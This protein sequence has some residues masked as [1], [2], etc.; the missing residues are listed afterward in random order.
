MFFMNKKNSVELCLVLLICGIIIGLKNNVIAAE[1]LST[2][3]DNR[4]CVAMDI[5]NY[6][7]YVTKVD[8]GSVYKLNKFGVIE[9]NYKYYVK[10]VYRFVVPNDGHISVTINCIDS[11]DGKNNS[12]WLWKE[13][14]F[15]DDTAEY[16]D[17]EDLRC[18]DMKLKDYNIEGGT[19]GWYTLKAGTYYIGGNIDG[20]TTNSTIVIN[21]QA[22]GAY[23]G[24]S[25]CHDTFDRA[26]NLKSGVVYQGDNYNDGFGSN[27]YSVDDDSICNKDDIY[28]FTMSSPGKVTIDLKS[29]SGKHYYDIYSESAD[30]NVTK[31]YD[32]SSTHTNLRLPQGNYYIVYRPDFEY[33]IC[34]TTV[35]ES[36]SQYEQEFNNAS[37]F[38]NEI[39][40]NQSYLGNINYGDDKD[41]YK[42]TINNK[43]NVVVSL[44]IP[45]Q[46]SN[47]A[48]VKLYDHTLKKELVSA[49]T[50]RNPVLYLK[51]QILEAGTYYVCVSG[52]NDFESDYTLT[53]NQADNCELNKTKLNLK[54]GKTGK[55]SLKGAKGNVA[56]TS[57]NKKVATV[58][59]SGKVKVTGVGNA[60]I[61][62][63]YGGR[64][65]TCKVKGTCN[66]VKGF[67]GDYSAYCKITKIKENKLYVTIS[68]SGETYK[69]QFKMNSS[70]TKA[71]VTFKC[72]HKKQHKITISYLKKKDTLSGSEKTKCK[73]KLW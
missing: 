49:D 43:S 70:G 18:F 28:R 20:I 64:Q 13:K 39:S 44:K 42:F 12:L 7:K 35:A 73:N 52:K 50:N 48:N 5:V 38:A 17:N 25:V 41:Y 6:D 71:T 53:I 23:N 57:S 65:Y 61:T 51:E 9:E 27:G 59:S 60:V 1:G 4:E 47:T 3:L 11:F 58:T 33:T 62:A 55:L 24:E 40:V 36:A 32:I 54:M 67:Y 46:S 69:K 29:A 66:F 45:R 15:R 8:F 63:A 22:L 26:D 21:Y 30:G 34:V 16:G 2:G 31:I 72:K 19:T 10:D 56:W 37:P 14:D 68:N